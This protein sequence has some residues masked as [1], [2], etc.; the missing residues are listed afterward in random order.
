[1]KTRRFFAGCSTRHLNLELF[2][3]FVKALEDPA[4]PE[5]VHHK[6]IEFMKSSVDHYRKKR[7]SNTLIELSN[8]PHGKIPKL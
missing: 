5:V 6:D 2:E 3:S 8:T 4:L 7:S 1:M